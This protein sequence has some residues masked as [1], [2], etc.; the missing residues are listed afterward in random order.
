MITRSPGRPMLALG[1]DPRP[2]F[3]GSADVAEFEETDE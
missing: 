1:S 2:V 3:T